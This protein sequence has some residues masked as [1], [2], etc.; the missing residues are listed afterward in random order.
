MQNHQNHHQSNNY[1]ILLNVVM[2]SI[3]PRASL[4]SLLLPSSKT[5]PFLPSTLTSTNTE[6][7]SAAMFALLDRGDEVIVFDPSYETYEAC[8]RMAGGVPIFVPLDPPLWTLNQEKLMKACT[9]KTKAI[10][11]NSPH[12]PTGKVFGLDELEMIAEA[13]LRNDC[14][15]VTDEVY[16]HITYE[17]TRH[18]SLASLPGM[19]ERTIITSSLSKTYSVTGWRVGWAIAPACIADA[20]RNIHIRLTDSA[21][22]PFQEAAL[23]ALQSPPEY[24][25]SL[26]QDYESRRNLVVEFLDGIGFQT[27]FKPQG[28][29]FIFAELHKDY[30]YS[31]VDFVEELITQAGVVAVPGCGFFHTKF[32]AEAYQRR[33]VRFAF[34]K[35]TATLTAAFQRIGQ[36]LDSSGHLKLFHSGNVPDL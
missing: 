7:F 32:P 15:A 18:I 29:F 1:H 36:L 20:I 27:H 11:M 19:Q 30:A 31:D 33:Y 21:P 3:L 26:K 12:N 25:E 13:C 8:I 22:A 9:V 14:L 2:P 17:N 5:L 10:I 4:T 28:S 23:T 16:E 35:T 34:C 6:A 24:F